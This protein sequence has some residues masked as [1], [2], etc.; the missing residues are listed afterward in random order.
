MRAP[1]TPGTAQPVSGPPAQDLAVGALAV[2]E[3]CAAGATIWCLAPA[4]P[5][6]ARH[7]AVE[8]V[9][10]VIMGKRALPAVAV[11]GPDVVGQLRLLC[12]P[13][14]VVV[15]VS[16]GDDPVV[17]DVVR[18]APAWG[19]TT[20]WVGTGPRPAAGAADHVLWCEG[21]EESVV[22][23]GR[24]VLVYHLLWELAHVCFEHPGL[25]AR[26]EGGQEPVCVTCSDEGRLAE[27]VTVGTASAATV[28]T[29]RGTEEID[30]TLVP[31]LR[32][33]DLVL[34]HAG[35]ALTLVEAER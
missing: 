11:E 8:F 30:V 21:D 7:V 14:D 20:L 16:R 12:R 34:V 13:G 18:R 22:H 33:G 28:R 10:P 23:G 2:A 9:H 1:G 26:E 4:W 25:V 3:R 5:A 31:A 19:A 24:L 32:P 15:A 6:H 17:A 35:T 27:V 29:A